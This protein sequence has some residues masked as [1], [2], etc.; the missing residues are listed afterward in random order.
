MRTLIVSLR[1][2]CAPWLHAFSARGIALALPTGAAALLAVNGRVDAQDLPPAAPPLSTTAAST[3]AVASAG[4]TAICTDR[5][6][7]SNSPCT[8]DAGHF[9]YE[10]D[11]VNYSSL[12]QGD[13]TIAT[14]LI[15]NPTLKYGVTDK[16]DIEVNIAALEI[17]HGAATAGGKDTLAG[18][19]DLYLRVKYEFANRPN[20]LQAAIIPYVKAPTARAGIGN[21]AVE[22]GWILPVAYE[23]NAVLTITLAPEVDIY[24]NSVGSGLHLNTAQVLTLSFNLP[25]NVTLYTELWGNWNFDPA[26][27]IRQRS[28]DFAL[29]F[30]P[31]NY[32]QVDAG[33]N[34][35][36]NRATPQVEAYLGLSQKF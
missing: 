29:A 8:A 18:V 30:A 21:G 28:L 32:L 11:L 36:L 14:W 33:V 27:T 9:Q 15:V 4:L 6:S 20:V 12:R 1:N 16:V 35:G 26:G 19:S 23:P 5:P 34:L 3:S 31:T 10:S 13:S 7:K 22:G 25:R 17:V 2:R 24:Q